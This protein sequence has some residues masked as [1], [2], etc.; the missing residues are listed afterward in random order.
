VLAL[1]AT[2]ALDDDL[3]MTLELS[4]LDTLKD[5]ALKNFE[6]RLS[7]AGLAKPSEIELEGARLESQL[8]QLYSFTALLARREPDMARTAELWAKLVKACDLFAG[9]IYSLAQEHDLSIS[10]YDRIL[11]IRAAAE[12]LRALHSA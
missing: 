1:A 7:K 5:T 10:A 4:D 8:E 9:R 11:D 12:E 3:A 2:V 6:A